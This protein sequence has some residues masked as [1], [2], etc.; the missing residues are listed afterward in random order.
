MPDNFDRSKL[1][2]IYQDVFAKSQAG[3]VVLDDLWFR[4]YDSQPKFPLDPL[5]LAYQA[6]QRSVINFIQLKRDQPDR[7]A[8]QEEQNNAT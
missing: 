5:A 7:E 1:P 6:G 8:Q 2:S 3:I 4:F